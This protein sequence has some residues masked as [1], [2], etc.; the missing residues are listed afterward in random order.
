MI[1]KLRYK[2]DAGKLNVDL[3]H[4][5]HPLPDDKTISLEVEHLKNGE[6]IKFM[7]FEDK[8]PDF[9]LLFKKKVKAIHGLSITD[10]DGNTVPATVDVIV[11]CPDP[12]FAR[13][14]IITC[15]HLLSSYN[16]TEDES[17]N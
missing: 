3:L 7:D 13:I 12:D 4:E 8:T 6:L 15:N 17:K 10:M 5:F 2:T 9:P 11:N 1:K 16:L 14:V